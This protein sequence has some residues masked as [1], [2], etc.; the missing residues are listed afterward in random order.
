M[1]LFIEAL[2]VVRLVMDSLSGCSRMD[3]EDLLKSLKLSTKGLSENQVI[4]SRDKYGTN[5]IKSTTK[6]PLLIEFLSKFTSPLVVILII[7][8][9]VSMII[10]E[11]IDGS[12]VAAM[13]FLSASLNFYQEYKAGN[14]AES[15]KKKVSA[16]ATVIRGGKSID[17]NSSDVVVGDLLE[18][19]SGDLISSDARIL[20]AKDLYINQSALT[21]ESYPVEKFDAVVTDHDPG[22]SEM[23]NI[24]FAG[25]SVVSGT[26]LAV[27]VKVGA[28]TEFGHISTHLDE[29]DDGDSFTKGVD[30]FG[31][32][33]LTIII[34]FVV[35]IFFANLLIKQDPY[36]SIL[37]AIAVA[38][39]LTPEF[40]PMIMTVTMSRGSEIMSKK[41]VIVKKLSAIPTFGSMDIL[42]TDKTG[43]LTEDR[44]RLVRY[45]DIAGNE[46]EEVFLN[47]YINSTLQTGITN[48]MDDA[49]KEYKKTNI[50]KYKKIDEIPFDFE[51]KRMSVVVD[52]EISHILITK[53]A[54]EE[55]VNICTEV[56]IGEKSSTINTA[57][58]LK[59]IKNYYSLSK[60]GFRV[61][62]VSIKKLS[63]SVHLYTKADESAMTLLGFIAFLDPAKESVRSSLDDL[64]AMGIEMK[65]ITGDSEFVTAKICEEVGVN[66]KGIMLGSSL[67]D[68]SDQELYSKAIKTTIFARFSPEQKRRVISVLKSRGKIVGYMGDGINDA[69]SLKAADVGISVSN[70]VDVAKASADIILTSKSLHDLKNG[71]IEGRK[72]LG[73]TLK[74]IKMGISSNFG[75]MFSVLGAVL[76]LPFLPMLPIQILLNNFLYDLGQIT[77]PF[78]E[79]DIE[80]TSK[81]KHFDIKEIMKSMLIFGPISSVFDFLSFFILYKIFS[82]NPAG[83]QTGWFMES[84]ATQTFVIYSIRT[85]KLPFLQSSPSRW[86]VISTALA[87]ITGWILPYSPIGKYFGFYPLGL[88]ILGLIA[89]IVFLYLVFVEIGKKI[90]NYYS[91]S[92]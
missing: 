23:T 18:L 21:G 6:H 65:V 27:V 11:V 33:I 16:K 66:V 61:L 78:D 17:I 31:K 48:P 2:F 1:R 70:G 84:L 76:F 81:P 25:T 52:N 89:G 13:V 15:L 77:L 80:Y 4:S 56:N 36:Q 37:F 35:F 47:A 74:Y 85:T 64:E 69:P 72:T 91:L 9:A 50:E 87:V 38:V 43:T 3:A 57:L 83:F 71:V 75:N 41:G 26:A 68:L 55:I 49:V 67:Y 59:I 20:K 7:I 10:G 92:K 46:S 14:A 79:V 44:I 29:I 34:I 19:N 90:N 8:S 54:P 12:I 45:I 22:I 88:P 42:C 51:R 40:L 5:D 58:R 24:V 62:A 39:G 60:Q 30:S 53:G 86:L 63:G 32:L 73:N 28:N 82:Q